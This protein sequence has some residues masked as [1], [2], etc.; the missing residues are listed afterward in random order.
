M[1]RCSLSWPSEIDVIE[2]LS[3]RVSLKCLSD[4][5]TMS[6]LCVAVG[7]SGFSVSQLIEYD[8]MAPV[9]PNVKLTGT[10]RWAGFGLGFLSPNLDCRK[11]SG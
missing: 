9:M 10:L 6:S 5:A 2:F 1:F 4:A 3:M 8:M 7:L 11:V